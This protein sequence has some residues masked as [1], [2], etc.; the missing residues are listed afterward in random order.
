MAEIFFEVIR[1]RVEAPAD[2]APPIEFVDGLSF[3]E[4]P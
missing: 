1:T 3:P 4:L 2:A